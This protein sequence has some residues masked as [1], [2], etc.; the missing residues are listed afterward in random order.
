MTGPGSGPGN[1]EQKE[2]RARAL[3]VKIVAALI[4]L[5]IIAV[6]G[7]FIHDHLL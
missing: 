2:R 3:T 6:V 5:Y 1:V 7:Y 4:V